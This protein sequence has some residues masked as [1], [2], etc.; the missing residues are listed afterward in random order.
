MRMDRA[1]YPV[2][3]DDSAIDGRPS[4]GSDSI[5][6]IE[7]RRRVFIGGVVTVAGPRCWTGGTVFE[8]VLDD[9]TG[10][11]ILAFLGF[12]DI[13]DIRPSVRL[14]ADGTVGTHRGRRLI[15]NPYIEI[16]GTND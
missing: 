11:V 5:G 8:C 10:Q 7:D 9:G 13:P 16:E 3:P 1:R 4:C 15:L 14:W 6:S 2:R 12:H